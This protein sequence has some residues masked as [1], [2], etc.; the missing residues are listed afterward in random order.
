MVGDFARSRQR[1]PRVV[2][3]AA[4]VLKL[5]ERTFAHDLEVRHAKLLAQIDADRQRPPGGQ[6]LVG[7]VLQNA[8]WNVHEPGD[9][10]RMI[11]GVDV[12]VDRVA[13]KQDRF[14]QLSLRIQ[15]DRKMAKRVQRHQVIA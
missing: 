3:L 5:R 1:R 4:R 6:E 12:L 7:L 8:Q 10:Q 9:Q 14:A 11:F 15:H 2:D 13:A